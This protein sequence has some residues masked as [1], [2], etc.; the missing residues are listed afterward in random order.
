MLN[1]S[2]ARS[3]REWDVDSHSNWNL[4]VRL[5][6]T[7]VWSCNVIQLLILLWRN[8]VFGFQ[9]QLHCASLSLQW[10]RKNWQIACRKKGWCVFWV[11]SCTTDVWR[12]VDWSGIEA[13]C[14]KLLIIVMHY[15]LLRLNHKSLWN[16]MLNIQ[17]QKLDASNR[18]LFP[19]TQSYL[20]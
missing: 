3:R 17:G 4:K 8:Q 9:S 10:L 16:Y 14:D 15:F 2:H 7:V 18:M 12:N 11:V 6:L 13:D 1:V 19:L 20:H 5:E